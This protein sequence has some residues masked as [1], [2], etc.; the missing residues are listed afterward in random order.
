M[1]MDLNKEAK[2]WCAKHSNKGCKDNCSGC[3]QLKQEWGCEQHNMES[4]YIAG[5]LNA[6]NRIWRNS[7]IEPRRGRYIIVK[8]KDAS[9]GEVFLAKTLTGGEYIREESIGSLQPTDIW[10]Y[11]YDILPNT[12]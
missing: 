11:L 7:Y 9:V 10:C 4:A 1:T 6:I 8:P 5:S 2:I 3:W 12:K